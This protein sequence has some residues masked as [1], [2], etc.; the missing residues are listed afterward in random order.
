MIMTGI[1]ADEF[2]GDVFA[3]AVEDS[4]TVEAEVTN[5][6]ATN[7]ARRRLTSRQLLQSGIDVS[8]TLQMAI[9]E[10]VYLRLIHHP[11]HPAFH[12]VLAEFESLPPHVLS[13]PLSFQPHHSPLAINWGNPT[14]ETASDVFTVL[15]A[16][17]TDVVTANDSPLV[18]ALAQMAPT[19]TVNQAAFVAPTTYAYAEVKVST[20]APT[21]SHSYPMPRLPR[22]TKRTEVSF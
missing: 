8:Y 9:E 16:D 19:I 15:V 18:A 20:S 7:I 17:L 10:G 2:D 14:G 21:V 11:P 5:V 13:T 6:V 22:E 4:L 12:I 3:Q 1:T